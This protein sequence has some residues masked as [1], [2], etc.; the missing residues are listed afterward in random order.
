MNQEQLCAELLRLGYMEYRSR[1]FESGVRYFTKHKVEGPDCRSNGEAPY[2][3]IMVYP[4]LRAIGGTEI[5]GSATF[6][7]VGELAEAWAEFQIYAVPYHRVVELT[8]KAYSALGRSWTE[9]CEV[10]R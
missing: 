8:E 4:M 5:P 9:A 1:L 10:F 3:E 7:V 2:L 6:K